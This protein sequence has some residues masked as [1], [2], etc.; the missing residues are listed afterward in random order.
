MTI[1]RR[2]GV[3][4]HNISSTPS[5]A[6]GRTRPRR[7]P[8]HQK[9]R[10]TSRK[11]STRLHLRRRVPLVTSAHRRLRSA[12]LGPRRKRTSTNFRPIYRSRIMLRSGAGSTRAT[13]SFAAHSRSLRVAR[14]GKADLP[15]QSSPLASSAM[16][17]MRG[18]A[19]LSTSRTL[20]VSIAPR[21]RIC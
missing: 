5:A 6:L 20:L 10:S 3:R 9:C 11:M 1:I 17:R 18:C 15:L 12:K 4:T 14:S 21:H 13:R 2:R 19:A 16:M 8:A 7:R